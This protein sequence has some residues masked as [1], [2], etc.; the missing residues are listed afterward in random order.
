MFVGVNMRL[1][2]IVLAFIGAD[3]V[4]GLLQSIYTK[5]FKSCVMREGL[6]HKISEVFVVAF[7]IMVQYAAPYAGLDFGNGLVT[8]VCV[9]I[10][11]MEIG[12]I[13]ENIRKVNPQMTEVLNKFGNKKDVN[14]VGKHDN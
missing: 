3:F 5:T 4:T 2:Y 7:A 12:S 10:I 8:S 6:M 1:V 11:V 14:E 13:A 9:Y